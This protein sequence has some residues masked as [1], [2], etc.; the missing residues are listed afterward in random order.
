MCRYGRTQDRIEAV[1][2][3]RKKKLAKLKKK[4]ATAKEGRDKDAVL[5]KIYVVSPFWQ[6]PVKA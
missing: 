6:E 2:D 3:H 5:K 1:A 4:L